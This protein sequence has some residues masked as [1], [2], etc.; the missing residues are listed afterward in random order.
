MVFFLVLF[1]LLLASGSIAQE[2]FEEWSAFT[3][4]KTINQV[5]VYDN[6]IWTATSGGVL[7]YNPTTG[8]YVRF[9]TLEGLASNQVLSMTADRHGNLWFGTDGH[10]LSRL[11]IDTNL[12]DIP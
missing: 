7:L 12:L 11:K 9:T 10:G 2:K 8:E 1:P 4:M 5:L 6:K 3:S